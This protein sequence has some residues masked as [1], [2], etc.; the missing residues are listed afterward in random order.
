MRKLIVAIDP[1]GTTGVAAMELTDDGFK[2]VRL[3]QWGDPDSVY[4]RILDLLNE[5][6]GEYDDMFVI[7]ESF[8][9]RPEVIDPDETPKY[10]I[11][12]LERFVEPYY[13][14][15]YQQASVAKVGVSPPRNGNPDRLKA[16]GLYQRGYRHAN[17]AIRHIVAY[18]IEKLRHRPLIVAGWG[19][20]GKK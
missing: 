20:P 6:S 8:E 19:L 10:I 7:C 4:E 3:Y 11:K 18:S 14:I 16:F 2:L 5:L 15:R 12:D 17:D 9:I 13:E 1:G